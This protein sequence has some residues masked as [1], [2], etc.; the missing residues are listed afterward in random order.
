MMSIAHPPDESTPDDIRLVPAT[1]PT[2]GT[3]FVHSTSSG[4]HRALS[5]LLD[6]IL[7][8]DESVHELKHALEEVVL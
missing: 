2:C 4:F 7:Q 8:I 1:C 3:Q 6:Q 5:G